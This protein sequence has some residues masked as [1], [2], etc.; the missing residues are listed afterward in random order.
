MRNEVYS[1]AKSLA[2][3]KQ[4]EKKQQRKVTSPNALFF[5]NFYTDIS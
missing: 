1:N 3:S 2:A 4:P 5:H